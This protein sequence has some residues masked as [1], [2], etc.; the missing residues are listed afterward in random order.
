MPALPL[1]RSSLQPR[2]QASHTTKQERES[3]PLALL[4]GR[5]ME[6]A[7]CSDPQD[8]HRCCRD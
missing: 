3:A 1:D 6:E 8:N 2:V 5:G 4:E 7:W